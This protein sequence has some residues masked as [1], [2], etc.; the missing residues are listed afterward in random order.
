MADENC[1]A[2]RVTPEHNWCGWQ[3][4]WGSARWWSA[5]LPGGGRDTV[6]V[7]RGRASTITTQRT[8]YGDS[9]LTAR[10]DLTW[11][12]AGTFHVS[13]TLESEAT[14]KGTR[15]SNRNDESWVNSGH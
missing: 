12:P 10:G 15:L 7:T 14:D 1:S 4:Q 6:T 5:N 3:G 2:G 13:T 11:P 9:Q 8:R